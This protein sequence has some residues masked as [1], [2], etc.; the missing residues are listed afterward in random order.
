MAA[1]EVAGPMTCF[2]LRALKQGLV[3][4]ETLLRS[5]LCCSIFSLLLLMRLTDAI[6]VYVMGHWSTSMVFQLWTLLVLCSYTASLPAGMLQAQWFLQLEALVWLLRTVDLLW[7]LPKLAVRVT[8]YVL[9]LRDKNQVSWR[10]RWRPSRDPSRSAV[11]LASVIPRS[12]QDVRTIVSI[13]LGLYWCIA[14]PIARAA[15]TNCPLYTERMAGRWVHF[16]AAFRAFL[17]RKDIYIFDD[18]NPEDI[19]TS[20]PDS[21]DTLA[22]QI[23]AD[24]G[25]AHRAAFTCASMKAKACLEE[26]TAGYG[27]LC[28]LVTN[29][30]TYGEAAVNAMRFLMGQREQT[31]LTCRRQVDQGYK[32]MITNP[33]KIPDYWVHL[34]EALIALQDLD[35][36][37]SVMDQRDRLL[38]V[39]DNVEALHALRHRTIMDAGY[40]MDPS[41][42]VEVMT[43]FI[44][45]TPI[46]M[47]NPALAVVQQSSTQQQFSQ[48]TQ[49][50]SCALVVT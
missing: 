44:A 36:P 7:T 15:V 50:H 2:P 17:I 34:H 33:Q 32:H 26:A 24:F 8:I 6:L 42:L 35:A 25:I 16:Y 39:C 19:R 49:C 30:A 23:L 28:I 14:V 29:S 1:E 4:I 20:Y 46:T 10:I 48:Q 41:A 22:I 40:M 47:E 9:K 38:N 11:T 37:I 12:F 13:L 31:I 21:A 5:V 3:L 27:P 43:K 18:K 45:L